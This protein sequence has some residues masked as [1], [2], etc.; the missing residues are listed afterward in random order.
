M[1]IRDSTLTLKP[2]N[3]KPLCPTR[4]LALTLT[5]TLTPRWTLFRSNLGAAIGSASAMAKSVSALAKSAGANTRAMPIFSPRLRQSSDP[6][7]RPEPVQ[8]LR[9]QTAQRL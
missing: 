4:F 8:R 6:Q 3:R 9:L 1:C 5:L 7:I 2:T